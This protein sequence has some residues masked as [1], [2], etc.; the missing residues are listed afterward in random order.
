MKTFNIFLIGKEGFRGLKSGPFPKNP[1]V[2]NR[3]EVDDCSTV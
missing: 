1:N 2:G 3:K